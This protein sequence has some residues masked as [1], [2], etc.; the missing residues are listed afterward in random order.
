M[1]IHKHKDNPWLTRPHISGLIS[2]PSRGVS[3]VASCSGPPVARRRRHPTDDDDKDDPIVIFF[4]GAGG[5]LALYVKVQQC[6]SA[7]VRAFLFDRAG[8]DRSSLRDN[9]NGP[10]LAEDGALDLACLLDT[11]D[12]SPPYVLVGHSFGG[13]CL[14]EFLNVIVASNEGAEPECTPSPTS[15]DPIL[16]KNDNGNGKRLEENRTMTRRKSN[17]LKD[18]IAGIV[19]VDTATELMLSLYP[20]VPAAELVA[21][22]ADVDWERVTHLREQSGMTDREW[23]DAIAA[24]VRT[25]H[26][27]AGMEDT[28]LSAWRLAQKRQLELQTYKG[29][30]L[31]VVRCN[32]AVDYQR[33]YDEGVKIGGG[34]DEERARARMFIDKW[35]TFAHEVSKAQLD[36]VED[37]DTKRYAY[38]DG[39]G[40]DGL[41]R[42]REMVGDPVRWVLSEWHKR[43]PGTLGGRGFG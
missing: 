33:M 19:L 26:K 40:H 15:T 11:L 9:D 35:R 16:E 22:A 5:P 34:T 31:S 30:I 43:R 12:I 39:F 1:T 28:H 42:K 20:R 41:L 36:L 37:E 17:P 24:A 14:R 25:R 7:F 21:V 18:V 38:L 8:Y 2:L 29:G 6:L 3:L 27:V 32:S 4:T 23:D 13:I 10:L